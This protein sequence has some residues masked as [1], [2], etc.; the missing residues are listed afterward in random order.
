[1][2]ICA[3]H[4]ICKLFFKSRVFSCHKNSISK[5]STNVLSRA[6]FGPGKLGPMESTKVPYHMPRHNL[7]LRKIKMIYSLEYFTWSL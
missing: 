7:N 1:M 2:A 3:L 6:E 5:L 4:F